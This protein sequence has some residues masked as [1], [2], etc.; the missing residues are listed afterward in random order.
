M[1]YGTWL[2]DR[3]RAIALIVIAGMV[4]HERSDQALISAVAQASAELLSQPG[5][6]RIALS[7][8]AIKQVTAALGFEIPTA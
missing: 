8:E 1:R 5:G 3:K 6:L 4:A 2:N 7:P